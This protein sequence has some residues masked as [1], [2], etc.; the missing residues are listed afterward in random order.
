VRCP[1]IAF[2]CGAFDEEDFRV[3]VLDPFLREEALHSFRR[4]FYYLDVFIFSWQGERRRP[5][6]VMWLDPY[7]QGNTCALGQVLGTGDC[8]VWVALEVEED[9]FE[10][11]D[12]FVG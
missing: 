1:L 4:T 8:G 11:S 3:A 10:T 5:V 2:A 7:N 6:V 9:G 12:D